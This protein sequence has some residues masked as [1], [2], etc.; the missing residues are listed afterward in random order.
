MRITHTSNTKDTCNYRPK[1][2]TYSVAKIYTYRVC[3]FK[4]FTFLQ[5]A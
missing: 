2:S 3:T 1:E 5:Y 4:H